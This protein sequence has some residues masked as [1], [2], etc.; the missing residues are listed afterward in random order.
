[1]LVAD[2]P[3]APAIVAVAPAMPRQTAAPIVERGDPRLNEVNYQITITGFS[4]SDW[5]PAALGF[6]GADLAL[7]LISDGPFSRVNRDSLAVSVWLDNQ[8]YPPA[9]ANGRIEPGIA[10]GNTLAVVPLPAFGG[11]SIRWQTVFLAESFEVSVD[12]GRAASITWP[13]EWPEEVRRFL[14]PETLIDS[15]APAIQAFVAQTSGGRLREVTPYVAAKELVRAATL[16]ARNV[17]GTGVVRQG[18]GSINGIDVYGSLSLLSSGN[19]TPADL[20]CLA[21]AALRAAGIPARP[22][23]GVTRYNDPNRKFLANGGSGPWVWGEF[24]LPNAGWIPFDPMMMRRSALRQAKIE[25]PWKGFANV[26]DM[27]LVIPMAW[28]FAPPRAPYVVSGYPAMWW[29]NVV[30]LVWTTPVGTNI[31]QN[32]N[33]A[34][35]NVTLTSRGR[36]PSN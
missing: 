15:A 5:S 8:P 27:N 11:Q 14:E 33:G 20:T 16:V 28:T 26:P 7:S 21:V 31:P 22:V 18:Y 9:N 2:L 6:P 35:L 23:L 4:G 34:Y 10:P 32:G 17:T 30:G 3:P 12:E 13:R 25:R 24:F 19:G 1:M 29:S 36:G